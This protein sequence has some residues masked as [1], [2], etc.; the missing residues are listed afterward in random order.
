[1]AQTAHP[2]DIERA[3]MGQES[4]IHGGTRRGALRHSSC[5]AF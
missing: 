4:V 5:Q 1:M 2:Y 3:R